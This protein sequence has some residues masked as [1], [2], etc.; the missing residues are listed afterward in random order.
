M[1]QTNNNVAITS[2]SFTTIFNQATDG[3]PLSGV[4]ITPSG[5]DAQVFVEGLH[6]NEAGFETIPSGV[7]VQRFSRVPSTGIGNITRVTARAVSSA[8]NISVNPVVR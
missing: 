6:V 1:S 4:E 2:A 3:G 8:S 7:T 5:G